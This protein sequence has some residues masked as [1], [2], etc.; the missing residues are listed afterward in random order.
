MR[1]SI[2]QAAW[3][4][5]A[6]QISNDAITQKDAG[7]RK[8]DRSL[9]RPRAMFPAALIFRGPVCA[10]D[11]AEDNK[12]DIPLRPMVIWGMSDK[13]PPRHAGKGTRL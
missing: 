3:T 8:I 2:F 10:N 11:F 1:S 9:V 7:S 6:D 12:A 13:K 4:V 5:E